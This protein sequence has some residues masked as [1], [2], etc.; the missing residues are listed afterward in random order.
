MDRASNHEHH[1]ALNRFHH[2][3]LDGLT[4]RTRRGMIRASL[5]GMA[6]LSLPD[7]LAARAGASESG[8]PIGGRKAV[9]LLWMAGG[10]SQIDTW[11]PKPD[12]PLENRGPFGVI[13]TR[14]PGVSICEHLPKRAAMLDKFTII[15]SVDARMSNHEPNE[16]SQTGNREAEPRVNPRGES[17]PAI[18]SVIAKHRGANAPGLPPHVAFQTSRS[19]IAYAGDLGAA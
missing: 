17:Y 6:G 7:L 9:I 19:H 2:D 15:R 12:R 11:D 1:H 4:L 8:R 13:P 5:A 10:P 16:V 3:R 14:L 18:G